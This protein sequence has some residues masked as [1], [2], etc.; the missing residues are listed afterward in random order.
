MLRSVSLCPVPVPY[1]NVGFN[2]LG[3]V[4]RAGAAFCADAHNP[5]RVTA[6]QKYRVFRMRCLKTTLGIVESS[7]MPTHALVSVRLKRLDSIRRKMGR[8]KTQFSLGS[9]DDVIGVRIICQNFQTVCDISERLRSLPNFYR[10]KDYI[11]N[12]HPANTGYRSVH[13]IMRFE[14]PL[15]ETKNIAVRFEIQIRS[16]YQ[17]QWAIWSESQGEAVKVGSGSEEIKATLYALSNRIANWEEKNPHKV[18][19]QLPDY[20]G[21][22]DVVVAWKTRNVK[23]TCN[24]F[25]GEVDRA[26]KWLNYLET[27]YPAQRSDALLLVGV[28]NPGEALKVLSLTHPLYVTK[29]IIEPQYWMPR[30]S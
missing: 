17:H 1:S 7:V 28:T 14:Q 9:M 18:Q 4:D 23:P 21:G 2:S 16:F 30:D 13:H 11:N 20:T 25:R 15:T 27:K 26:V 24:V 29:R 22:E 19:E 3:D 6:V 12:P 10:Q 5:L 8:D